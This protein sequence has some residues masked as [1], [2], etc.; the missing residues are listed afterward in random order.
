MRHL[1]GSPNRVCACRNRQAKPGCG[2]VM[3]QNSPKPAAAGTTDSQNGIS[4]DSFAQ[5]DREKFAQNMLKVG[6]QTQQLLSEFFKRLAAREPGPLDPLNVSGAFLS[7]VKD[8]GQDR[9]TV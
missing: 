6:L 3:A 7:L 8:M 5:I 9:Q 2:A 1:R 4:P